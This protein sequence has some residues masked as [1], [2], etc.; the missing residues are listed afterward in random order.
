MYCSQARCEIAERD[1][2]ALLEYIEELTT[3]R[4][5]PSPSKRMSVFSHSQIKDMRVRFLLLLSDLPIADIFL[6]FHFLQENSGDVPVNS[7][8]AARV[9][10]LTWEPLSVSVPLS[11]AK[12]VSLSLLL[13]ID[14]FRLYSKINANFK[15]LSH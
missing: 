13:S 3:K 9:M 10:R 11:D 4:E 12:G 6:A 8:D 15:L 2:Q 5:S 14:R 7:D 1:N